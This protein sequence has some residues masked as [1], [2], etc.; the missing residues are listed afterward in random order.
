MHVY[1]TGGAVS[2]I[3]RAS[4]DHFGKAVVWAVSNHLEYLGYPALHKHTEA[5]ISKHLEVGSVQQP[6]QTDAVQVL[7]GV[8]GLQTVHAYVWVFVVLHPEGSIRECYVDY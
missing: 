3:Y 1:A 2:K 5:A 8:Y 7:R 4:S 6:E